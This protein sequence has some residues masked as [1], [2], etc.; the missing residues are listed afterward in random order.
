M[1]MLP[2]LTKETFIDV[3]KFRILKWGDDLNY[4]TGK[5]VTTRVYMRETKGSDSEKDA[6]T[7][8]CPEES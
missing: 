2:Y 8:Q 6:A 4:S 3:N 1:N 5:N 7:H